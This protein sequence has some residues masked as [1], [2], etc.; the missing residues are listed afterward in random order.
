MG[1]A[2]STHESHEKCIQSFSLETR[3]N[4]LGELDKDGMI[5]LKLDLMAED[6][7]K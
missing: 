2:Y 3:R 1:E 4:H 6:V 7:K 5:I